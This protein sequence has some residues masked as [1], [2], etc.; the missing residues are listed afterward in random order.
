[1][2][3]V[4]FGGADLA[5]HRTVGSI[6]ILVS[7]ASLAASA[8]AGRKRTRPMV[9]LGLFTLLFLQPVLAFAFRSIPAVAA[10]HAVN[11]LFAFLVALAIERRPPGLLTPK[12]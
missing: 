9:A 3:R 11:G 1:V 10:L 5:P 8:L 7:V 2:G 12:S 6:V 4:F